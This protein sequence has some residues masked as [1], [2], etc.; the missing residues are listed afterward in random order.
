MSEIFRPALLDLIRYKDWTLAVKFDGD[1]PYLQWSF[2]APCVATGYVEE[3][4]SRKWMLSHHMTDSEVV[5]TAFKAAL[6]AEEH[7]CREAF[8]FK[9]KPI[10]GPH[11]SVDRLAELCDQPGSVDARYQ[12]PVL[13]AGVL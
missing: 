3:L 7:E 13:P 6:T 2:F 10:F 4:H 1:R 9:A 11:F 8:L 5:M 12:R